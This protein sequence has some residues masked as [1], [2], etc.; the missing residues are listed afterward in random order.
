MLFAS[1]IGDWWMIELDGL[2]RVMF[3]IA[4]VTSAIFLVQ[5]ILALIGIGDDSSLD[6]DT[7]IAS[8][9]TDIFNN[10]PFA[11]ISGLRLLSFRTVMAFLCVGA[12][13]L[14]LFQ[15]W[16]E[17]Y[18][19]ATLGIVFGAAAAV[20]VAFLVRAI[21]RMQENGN[22]LIENAIGKIGDVYL[23][24][25]GLRAGSGKVTLVVQDSFIERE[26]VTDCELDIKT[27]EKVRVIDAINSSVLLV[28][29]VTSIRAEDPKAGKDKQPVLS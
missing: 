4:C 29:P 18:L 28:E 25:P 1:A 9:D 6:M 13:S 8:A 15:F 20:G 7:D 5:L 14:F 26:A 21:F 11:T 23:R 3:I 16:M 10:E 2:Q 17:W 27:G 19:S 12:W 22:I 24:I